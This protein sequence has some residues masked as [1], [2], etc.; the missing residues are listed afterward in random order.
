[1]QDYIFKDATVAGFG[2]D[3]LCA[4]SKLYSAEIFEKDAL[5]YPI[6]TLCAFSI[7]L[8]F[9]AF[10]SVPN[11][12]CIPIAGEQSMEYVIRHNVKGRVYEHDLSKLFKIFKEGKK[13]TVQGEK[14]CIAK[15]KNNNK[16]K[17]VCTDCCIDRCK[18]KCEKVCVIENNIELA[19]H[20]EAEYLK[21]YKKSLEED[22]RRYSDIFIE[23]RYAYEHPHFKS[24]SETDYARVKASEETEKAEEEARQ[25]QREFSNATGESREEAKK[26]AAKAQKKTKEAKRSAKKAEAREYEPIGDILTNVFRLASFLY[27]STEAYIPKPEK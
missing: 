18:A 4:A 9:K 27:E 7:E 1:M 6:L 22:L 14:K 15:C 16:D 8:F 13:C 3:Y 25:K 17:K 19:N 2:K 26:G 20:L 10:S 11:D 23:S 24:A 5:P 21:L 12:R